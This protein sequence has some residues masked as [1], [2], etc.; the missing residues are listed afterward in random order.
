[1]NRSRKV[2]WIGALTFM[3]AGAL[4]IAFGVTVQLQ[5]Y[6]T[7]EVMLA[8][9]VT[10]IP[11][12]SIVHVFGSWDAIND[13]PVMVGTNVIANSTQ[14]DDVYLGTTT[15]FSG[16]YFFDTFEFESTEV[17]YVYVRFFNTNADPVVGWVEW[18]TSAM[19][20][21]TNYEP[22]QQVSVDFGENKVTAT[23]YFITIPEPGTGNLALV[24]AGVMA[25]LFAGGRKFGR[26]SKGSGNQTG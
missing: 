4:S 9:G 11:D 12:G 22:F 2:C 25:G 24:A 3:A 5:A 21:V 18:G 6:V 26:K 19:F 10:P 13:G 20:V 23:N 14:N 7:T 16:G 15:I 17:R 1:M 8:D